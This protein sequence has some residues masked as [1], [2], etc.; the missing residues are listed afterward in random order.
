M[1]TGGFVSEP[2]HP[3]LPGMPKSLDA[4]VLIDEGRKK[5]DK[6][7]KWRVRILVDSTVAEEWLSVF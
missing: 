3:P 4:Q 2:N 6:K 1:S 5:E 7:E